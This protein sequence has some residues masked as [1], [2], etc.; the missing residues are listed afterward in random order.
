MGPEK[1]HLVAMQ[2]LAP[3][4]SD[5]KSDELEA[6][7]RR[8]RELARIKEQNAEEEK[9]IVEEQRKKESLDSKMIEEPLPVASAPADLA[10][11]KQS[12]ELRLTANHFRSLWAVVETSGSFQCKIKFAPSLNN[13]TEHL[14]RQGFHIVFA[15]SPASGGVEVGICNIRSTGDDPWFMARFMASASNFSA[16]MKCQDPTVVEKFVKKFALAKV[17]K[18]EA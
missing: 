15:S 18:I 16:V 11:V 10:P 17:L 12:S 1:T 13:F 7:R 9:A 3:T 8:E 6:E 4:R 14:K 2:T 5:K